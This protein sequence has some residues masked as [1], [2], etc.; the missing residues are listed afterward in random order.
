MSGA[1]IE[2]ERVSAEYPGAQRR[3]IDDIDL[4]VDPGAFITLVGPSGCGKSTLLRTINRL[5]PISGGRI[6]FDGTDSATL[7]AVT[8]RRSIGYAIQATGLFSHLDV[9]RNVGVVP[10][11]L[12]WD[13]ERIARACRRGSHAGTAR[14]GT[15]PWPAS[16][17]AIRRRGAA[18]RRG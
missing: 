2:L 17:R 7:D 11:L 10:S 3:A 9:A 12:G 13:R 1:A 18:G 6:L 8:M 15:L 14:S 4:H 16:E 5:V